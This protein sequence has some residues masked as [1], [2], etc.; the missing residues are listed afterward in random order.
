MRRSVVL[1]I[2]LVSAA[3]SSA[4]ADEHLRG[5]AYLAQCRWHR[6]FDPAFVPDAYFVCPEI[7]TGKPWVMD[8]LPLV[9]NIRIRLDELDPPVFE[10]HT[11]EDARAGKPEAMRR[12]GDLF[13][14]SR[15]DYEAAEPW[16]RKAAVKGDALAMLSMAEVLKSKDKDQ[17]L[18]WFDDGCKATLARKD[19]PAMSAVAEFYERGSLVPQDKREMDRWL[20]MAANAGYGP[21]MLRLANYDDRSDAL[22]WRMRAVDAF[23]ERTLKSLASDFIVAKQDD[24]ALRVYRRAANT[25]DPWA[26]RALG[27]FYEAKPEA[28]YAKVLHWY[29]AAAKKGDPDAMSRLGNAYRYGR[30][31]DV[32]EAAALAWFRMENRRRQELPPK[33]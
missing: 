14:W 7:D 15:H 17:A 33:F 1:I 5:N 29:R 26:M 30:G 8:V 4:S 27:D 9:G 10:R 11:V 22:Y 6:S 19:I 31:V 2:A 13:A 3:G 28:D 16:Y 18:R 12:I 23:D 24:Q 32:D 20:L 21:A 25:G